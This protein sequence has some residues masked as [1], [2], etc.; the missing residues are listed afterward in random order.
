MRPL[1]ERMPIILDPTAEAWWLDASADTASLRALLVPYHGGRMEA[2]PVS[3]WVSNP[4]HQ[5]PRCLEPL[6]L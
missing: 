1:H 5:G 3:S 2:F 4:K 6:H